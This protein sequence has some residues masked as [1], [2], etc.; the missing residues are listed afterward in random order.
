M[1]HNV[2]A[3]LL[4]NYTLFRIFAPKRSYF[5]MIF[6]HYVNETDLNIQIVGK[7]TIK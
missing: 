2:F 5:F 1:E 4:P 6:L 7:L 3:F